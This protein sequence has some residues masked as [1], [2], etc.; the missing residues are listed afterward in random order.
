MTELTLVVMAAGIGSRYGGL[1]QVDPI[2]PNGEILIHYSV[3]DALRAGFSRV[4]FVI[5]RDIESAFRET[6]GSQI[7]RR[8]DVAYVY[9]ELTDLPP[10]FSLPE[11]RVKPWGTAHAVLCCKG[12]VTTPFSAINADDFYGADAYR[13]LATHL[14]DVRKGVGADDYC[15]VG[16][17]LRNTLSEHGHV[18]RGVCE[19]TSEGYLKSIRERTRIEMLPDGIKYLDVHDLWV[20]LAADSAVSMNIWGFTLS[21]FDLLEERF[22]RFLAQNM[23][24]PKSEFLLPN[25]VGELVREGLASVKVLHTDEHWF[26]VTY[27][28]DR[29]RVQAAVQELMAQGRYPENLWGDGTRASTASPASQGH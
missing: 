21:L 11:G 27:Q 26:G 18:A 19:V 7:E 29:P 4:V 25:F 22:P 17:V 16:Y 24:N 12:A 28:A 23:D 20:P 8:T 5:R 15:M 1:K 6:I 9:Q 14:S 3:Y 10:G 2:G 13:A